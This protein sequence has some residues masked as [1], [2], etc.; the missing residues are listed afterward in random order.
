MT[1]NAQDSL[2][3][4]TKGWLTLSTNGDVQSWDGITL[5]NADTTDG[6]TDIKP[7]FVP[8]YLYYRMVKLLQQAYADMEYTKLMYKR[9]IE[10]DARRDGK[11][12]ELVK[13]GTQ[14]INAEIDENNEL[15]RQL[16]QYTHIIYPRTNKI[17]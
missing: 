7:K 15:K 11:V 17:K 14:A 9:H 16:S 10:E 5:D 6:T 3:K 1:I 2:N 13:V 4:G 8:Y 12:M